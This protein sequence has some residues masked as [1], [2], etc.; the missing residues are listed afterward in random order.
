MTEYYV[1][2]EGLIAYEDEPFQCF[3]VLAA[4]DTGN[5]DDS[6]IEDVKEFMAV[7]VW[8]GWEVVGK[9]FGSTFLIPREGVILVTKDSIERLDRVTKVKFSELLDQ[10]ANKDDPYLN[11][12]KFK[13]GE[14]LFSSIEKFLRCVGRLQAQQNTKQDLSHPE[15]VNHPPESRM[16]TNQV[17]DE[18]DRG[19][20]WLYKQIEDG[21][22]NRYRID[23]NNQ[24]TTYYFRDEIEKIK[25]TFDR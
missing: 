9:G 23:P 17:I 20:S 6:L 25:K 11:R 13:E 1:V 3:G 15:K 19:R 2:G 7:D 14:P 5:L 8:D 4:A 21:K 10:F 18:L 12:L 22:I 16:S 24:K